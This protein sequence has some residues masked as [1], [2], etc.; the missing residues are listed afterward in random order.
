MVRTTILFLVGALVGGVCTALLAPRLIRWWVEPVVAGSINSC[1]NEVEF[2]MSR[3]LV[4][5]AV[6]AGISSVVF[7]IAGWLIARARANKRIAAPAS[8]PP[9]PPGA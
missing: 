8:Q 4:S 6:G 1:V 3:L 5:Q 2:A 7:A 9:L